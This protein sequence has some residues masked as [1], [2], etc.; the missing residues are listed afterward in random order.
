MKTCQITY[1]KEYNRGKGHHKMQM[2]MHA[3]QAMVPYQNPNPAMYSHFFQPSYGQT[4]M[5]MAGGSG[6]N[7]S[8]NKGSHSGVINYAALAQGNIRNALGLRTQGFLTAP[9]VNE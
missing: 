5:Q 8:S 6:N 9:N 1:I 4:G 7:S 3:T 2:Q